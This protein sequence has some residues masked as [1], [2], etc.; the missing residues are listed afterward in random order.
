MTRSVHQVLGEIEKALPQFVFSNSKRRTI[1]DQM[2]N[3]SERIAYGARRFAKSQK[4][5]SRQIWITANSLVLFHVQA[6][7]VVSYQILVPT[8]FSKAVCLLLVEI[9][10]IKNST[11]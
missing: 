5:K 4:G 3:D 8:E 6:T 7:D 2:P 1:D 9:P 11:H 10:P